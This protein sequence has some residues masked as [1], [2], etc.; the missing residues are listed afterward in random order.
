MADAVSHDHNFK[1]LIVDYPRRALEFFAPGEAPARSD[2][3]SCVPVRQEQLKESLGSRFRASAAREC[4]SILE[5]ARRARALDAPFLVEWADGRRDAVAFAVEEESD[6]R[7]FSAHRLAHYCLDLADMLG[8]DR[9]VPVVI[10]LRDAGRAP[11]SLALGT[12][13]RAYLSFEYVACK[14]AQMPVDSWLESDN[15]VARINLPNMRSPPARRVDVYGQAVRGLLALEPDPRRREKYLE[16][17]DIY[18]DL[19]DNER[20]SYRRRYP[21]ES[22]TM[23]GMFQRAREESMQLG[24]ERG[25]VE[26]ERAVLRR[27]L[28]RRFG[29]LSPET[30][31]RVDHASAR[32]LESWAENVLDAG[33]LDE[34]FGSN[35]RRS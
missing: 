31:T 12:E 28:R 33:T 18:A 9:V 8:T 16:F 22:T 4:D 26:G 11:T 25:R 30:V 6:W 7:R 14:L 19:T 34:V 24:I 13:R 10:F 3:A 23:A 35:H 32:D 17:I 1:N 15:V 2:E 29:V 20:Q 21:E 5:R 27:L